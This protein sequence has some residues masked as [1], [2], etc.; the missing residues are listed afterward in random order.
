MKFV[1]DKKNGYLLDTE[2]E[3]IF[4]SE[5][6]VTAPGDYVKVY[7]YALM[8]ANL[9]YEISANK[10]AKQLMLDEDKIE[11]AFLYWQEHGVIEQIDPNGAFEFVNLRGKLFGEVRASVPQTARKPAGGSA[12]S[13]LTDKKLASMYKAI[14]KIIGKPLGGQDPVQI[15]SWIEDFDATEEMIVMAY[16]YCKN[17][18]KKDNASYVGKVVKDWALKGLTDAEKIDDY[19]GEIERNR[20]LHKRVFKALGFMR[21]PTEEEKR[22][23]DTWFTEMDIPIHKV[24]EACSKTSGISNPNINYINKILTE[25]RKESGAVPTDENGNVTVG[26]VMKYYDHIREEEEKAAEARTAEIYHLLPDIKKLDEEIRRAGMETSR[27]LISGR[28]DRKEA[29]QEIRRKVEVMMADRAAILTENGFPVDYME[30]RYECPICKDT[31][32]TEGGERCSC[33]K[34]RMDEAKTWQISLRK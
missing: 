3:N 34:Q 24:L 27:I 29:A 17:T 21:N 18:Y 28:A 2:V 4:I 22:I 23:M 20:V 6:M 13:A 9:G 31:G 1:N 7:L 11:K 32:T 14:E 8:C 26:A 16:S 10:L 15:L 33:F 5:H 25:Q 19:L 12:Y 30:V